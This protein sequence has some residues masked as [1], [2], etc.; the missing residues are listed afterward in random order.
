MTSDPQDLGLDG[1]PAAHE[2]LADS[3]RRRVMLGG[4]AFGSKLPTERDLALGL[5]V[6][7]NTVRQAMRILSAEGLVSTT[8]GRN[9]G[10]VVELPATPVRRRRELVAQWRAS[11]DDAY[12]YRLVLEPLAAR[13][14]AE[15]ASVAQRRD[16]AALARQNSTD[17]GSYHQLDS[18]FH[19]LVASMARHPLLLESITRAREEMFREVNTLWMLEPDAGDDAGSGMFARFGCEHQAIW[20]AIGA[21]DPDA[22]ETAMAAHLQQAREQFADLLLALD[23]R[24]GATS[25]ESR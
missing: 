11:I 9:G 18:R 6:S 12:A 2:A 4:F 7:R 16:L 3:V 21:R 14:A 22:A 15:R 19:L 25:G 5:G 17:L 8:R 10:S 23:E 13:W 24:T 1:R 20:A